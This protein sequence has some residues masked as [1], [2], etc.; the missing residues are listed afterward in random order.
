MSVGMPAHLHLEVFAAIVEAAFGEHPYHVGSSM[1]GKGWRDVDVRLILDDDAFDALFPDKASRANSSS[2]KWSATCMAW[3][4]LGEKMT[5]LP[6]DF[7]IQRQT[8]A[9]EMFPGGR[10]ALGL[11]GPLHRLAPPDPEHQP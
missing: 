3:S 6:I 11:Q 8:E 10:G 5:G 2:K 4:A 7:Q 1:T 9:N